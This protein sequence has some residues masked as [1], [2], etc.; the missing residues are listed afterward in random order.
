MKTKFE[1]L[2]GFVMTAVFAMVFASTYTSCVSDLGN[3]VSVIKKENGELAKE[4]DKWRDLYM[5]RTYTTQLCI[6]SADEI[7]DYLK[8]KYEQDS[9]KNK[10]FRGVK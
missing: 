3:E 6:Y 7:T 1:G 2:V 9:K 4:R 5:E 8:C 10:K